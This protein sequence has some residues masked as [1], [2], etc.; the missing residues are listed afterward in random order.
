MSTTTVSMAERIQ[1]IQDELGRARS[2]YRDNQPEFWALEL[3]W[4]A[5]RLAWYVVHD[6]AGSDM[7]NEKLQSV[8]DAVSDFKRV[9]AKVRTRRR[10]E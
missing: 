3:A 1:Q 9:L 10:K 7:V 5:V 6:G 2:Q 8:K 4:E